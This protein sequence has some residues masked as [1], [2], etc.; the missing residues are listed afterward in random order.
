MLSNNNVRLY[1]D[2]EDWHNEVMKGKKRRQCV[3]TLK[4]VKEYVKTYRRIVEL[5]NK[6][7]RFIYS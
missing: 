2:L 7:A 1:K 3:H 4:A 5:E 6:D